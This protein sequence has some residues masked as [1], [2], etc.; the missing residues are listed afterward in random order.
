MKSSYRDL[1]VWQKTMDLVDA[2]Y[3]SVRKFPKDEIFGL[4]MQMRRA[5]ANG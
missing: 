5:A 3:L 1:L 4:G 2:V